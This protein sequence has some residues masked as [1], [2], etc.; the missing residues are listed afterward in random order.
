MSKTLLLNNGYEP[1]HFIGERSAIR[2]IINEKVDVL[3]N[4]NKEEIKWISGSIKYPAT[5]KLKY[6]VRQIFKTMKFCRLNV[7]KRDNFLCAYCY[8]ALTMKTATI[9]HIVP[10]SRGGLN[11]WKNCISSCNRCN[12]I[13]NNQTP[14]EAGMKLFY[15]ATLPVGGLKNDYNEILVRH[16]DWENYI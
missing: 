12:I 15:Q 13:K 14:E 11:I 10:T 6:R 7:F 8:T 4:W 1:I 5:I 3:A 2:L 9:D 16:E